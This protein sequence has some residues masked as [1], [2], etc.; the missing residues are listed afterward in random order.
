MT[1]LSTKTDEVANGDQINEK[2][3][4][5]VNGKTQTTTNGDREVVGAATN[6]GGYVTEKHIGRLARLPLEELVYYANIQRA[7]YGLDNGRG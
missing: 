1:R 2:G 6:L 5:V 3:D 4:L 7:V